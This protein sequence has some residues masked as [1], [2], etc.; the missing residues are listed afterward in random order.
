MAFGVVLDACVL[1]PAAL[2]DVLLRAAAAGLFRVH[3]S[4][5]L[6]DEMQRNLVRNGMTTPTG[7]V[8]LRQ[9]ME[10]NFEGA[11]VPSQQ[12]RPLIPAMTNNSKDRHVLAAAVASGSQVIVTSNLRD[13]PVEA[14]DP[15]EVEVQSPDEFLLH[16]FDLAPERMLQIVKDQAAAL[17]RPPMPFELVVEHLKLQAPKFAEVIQRAYQGRA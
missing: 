17:R 3:W 15:H 16:L 13:F 9:A 8:S 6:L 2:R 11:A 10:E 4:D 5:D 14:L 1:I 7:A 12:Y